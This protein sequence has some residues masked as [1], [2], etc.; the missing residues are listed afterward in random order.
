MGDVIAEYE[1]AVAAK[2]A[3]EAEIE[4][5]GAELTSGSNPGLHG[6]LVDAEGFP[7]ADIDVYRVRQLRHTL[8]V[9]R[10]DHQQVMTQ[11]EALLPQ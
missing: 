8:A 1:R 4:A 7:R 2:A 9:R 5:V 6:P 10:T 3:I 11:I